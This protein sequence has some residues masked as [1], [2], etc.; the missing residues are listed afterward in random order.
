[1]GSEV[2]AP[3]QGGFASAAPLESL[4]WIEHAASPIT[5]RAAFTAV[6]EVLPLVDLVLRLARRRMPFPQF[7]AFDSRLEICGAI[8]FAYLHK[9]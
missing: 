8:P 4:R 6:A 3:F 5:A 9:S 2:N 1:M 7:D